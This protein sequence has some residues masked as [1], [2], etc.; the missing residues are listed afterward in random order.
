MKSWSRHR[1]VPIRCVLL[2][3][4]AALCGA[5]P[6]SAQPKE[7][8]PA[9][10]EGR[11]P[12]NFKEMWRGFDP[13]REPLNVE[14]VKEWEEDGVVLKIVRF[15]IGVFK[16]HEAKLAAVY[17]APKGAT[18]LP[19]LVQIHGGGQYADHKACVA[20]AKR[21]Y[22]T[23]S[24]AWAGRI[25]APGHR[26]SPDEVKLFWDQKTDDPAYR[27]TTDWGVVDGYH[28]PSRNRGNQFPSAKPAEW[29][30]DTVESPRNS[31]W[32]LCAM[33][34]RRALTF[35]ESQPEVDSERLGVYGHSMGGKL[36]ILTA[37][38]SRVKAA[39]PSC[40]GI[41]DRY[42]DSELFRKT[43]GDDVSLREIQCP[44]I[45][46]SPANDFHGRIGDL[47]SAIS[48][49]QSND[50]RVTC[51]PHHNHQDTPAYEAATLLWFDQHLKNAF[52]FPKSPQLTMDWDGADGVPKAEVQ[53]DA[54][55]PIESVDAY[56]TQNGK[57]GETPADRDDVVHRFWHHASAVQSGDAWTA[58]MPISSVSKPLWVYA[59][60]T[61][62][63]PESVEGV[64]YYYRTYRTDEVNL[65]SV[66]QMFG[67]EQ[68]VTE[69]VK[70]TKQRTTL[71]EDFA[72]DWEHEWFTY[73]PEQWARTTNKFSADQY[74]APAGATLVLE[75]QS[76]QANSLV[77]M[78]DGHAA[79]VELVGG[80][81]WQTITLSPDDFENAAGE[82][83]AHWDGIRQLKLSDAERLS[84]GRGESAHSR[85]VGRRWKGEPPQFRNLRW[86]TQTVHSTEPRL[87]V[88]P[89]STVGVHS[90]NGATHFQTEY[91]PSPSVWDDRIDEA[92]VF[93][94]EMQHQQS[95][96]DSFQLRMGKGGQIYSLRGSFGES[97]P[98]SWR[99]PGGKLSPWN[100]EVWQFV[101]VCTQYNG[102]K[103]LR[104]NRRQSEQDSSQVEAV[105]NQLSELG[106]SDTFFVHNSG[107]YIP[108][109]SEL[110]SLYCPLLAYEIDEEARAI[111]M[112][113]WGLVPQIRS[114]HRSP[115][116]YYTQIRDAGDGVI[117]MTWVVHN[118]SQREDVVFDHLNAP[119]GGTRI[120]SLPLRYVASPE[121]ELLE[122]E[123]FL[124]E[125]GTVNVRET[126][127]WNLSCQS[128]ADDSPSL[129][130]V[131][132]RDKHLER[133]LERK[134]NGE[135]YCQFKHSLYRDWRANEPLYQTE[136]K[137]WAT[138][139]ENSFRNYDV[140][141]II[142][143][144]RIVPGST[145]WFRSYL[146]VGEKAQAMQRAQSLVDHV[147]YG[148]L[149]FDADQCPMTTVV[150]DG[151]SMQLFAK[152]VPNSLPVFEIE[153]AETGQNVLSTDLYFFVENRSLDLDLPS[154]HPQRDYFASVRGY[155]L[156]R[157]HS[158][159][160]RLVGYAMAERPAEN[161]SNTSGNWKRLSRVLKSQVAAE[162]NKYHRDVWV[163]CSD[164]ASPVETRATE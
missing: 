61:Y 131:Y 24:I 71:I 23:I 88:F 4:M 93:Q 129:A 81:T 109:S 76:G 115:L 25:S 66:V 69:D 151:V 35:L 5:D 106:L 145:I 96:A 142:P 122:R 33:A 153:H 91:S 54:S 26:V 156:D 22:A 107:A 134:A 124:S 90:I 139:P 86:T 75:V 13:R 161:D 67:A 149:D 46:L 135:A 3:L 102:I 101:A 31:G 98:P 55:M 36:T 116:L 112:L 34:A 6:A 150:R 89:A 68:L 162:D 128:D 146:V 8:L 104:A 9:V 58:K 50:W 30:L 16:G 120:S 119:W 53:V 1:C 2:A 111:R 164:S 121:G 99:K 94:V 144:L 133:E 118:F 87:D 154:Q 19:G 137:D 56:Y 17:G 82:S 73:R 138:R 85:I 48:E 159:W 160:K 78:I 20:N 148:L 141:E 12:E 74:K 140:C 127:G 70:A 57:L 83:L 103:T 29:T 163:Q 39:A 130:L 62:R 41:S 28:A 15:R 49:I 18:N 40:G 114:V 126:A 155:F 108:N 92:A 147:D 14:V 59:N 32:F 125:H 72:S 11:A 110:K 63:L 42:N 132:G 52:Q 152:P 64:G 113:N 43:L 105:K 65:S 143:K 84:S 38:D 45:F 97:L 79:A 123:G 47:P 95:P 158:K 21:G 44:I 10:V 7:T 51:S 27:Q 157:N 77:V 136:W 37:V 60:V 117:E 100:D 80:E